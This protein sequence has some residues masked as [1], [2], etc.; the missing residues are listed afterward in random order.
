M[1]ETN[2]KKLKYDDQKH[3]PPSHHFPISEQVQ[4]TPKRW[5]Q[6]SKLKTQDTKNLER[7]R[8]KNKGRV[9]K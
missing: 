6:T 1:K 3:P 8:K 4:T 9:M 2:C 7:E 5:T